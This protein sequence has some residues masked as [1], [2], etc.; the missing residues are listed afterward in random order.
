MEWWKVKR[1]RTFAHTETTFSFLYYNLIYF[2]LILLL[3]LWSLSQGQRVIMT[4]SG[5]AV[6]FPLPSIC[7]ALLEDSTLSFWQTR[8]TARAGSRTAVLSPLLVVA[9]GET[10]IDIKNIRQK[11]TSS[12][13][14]RH[15]MSSVKMNNGK[16]PYSFSVMHP[17]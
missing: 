15:N 3:F 9:L 12:D 6:L 4:G 11:M 1:L 13:S 2:T 7:S 17:S 8:G 10:A 14:I 5:T 16:F